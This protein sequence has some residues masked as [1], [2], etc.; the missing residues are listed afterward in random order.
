MALFG[1]TDPDIPLLTAFYQVEG[2]PFEPLRG[3]LDA[4]LYR[5]CREQ[6]EG[7]QQFWSEVSGLS[8]EESLST[9]RG[10]ARIQTLI[11]RLMDC[12]VDR[13]LPSV[14]DY[15]ELKSLIRAKLSPPVVEWVAEGI[16]RGFPQVT[17][18]DGLTS[19]NDDSAEMF[20]R[21][22]LSNFARTVER[23][24]FARCE[25]CNSVFVAARKNQRYCSERCRA[26]NGI[27]R[28][29]KKVL[30]REGLKSKTTVL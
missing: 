13:R 23:E 5:H 3:E 7:A 22:I 26:R 15:G 20:V 30:P 10:I 29:R 14:E 2:N 21:R 4:L 8:E 1:K 25:E 17:Y 19:D 6:R 24:A 27:R 28:R 11:V 18:F 12:T 16:D 9:L